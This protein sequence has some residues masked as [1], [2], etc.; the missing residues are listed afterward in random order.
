[1]TVPL[2]PEL[3]AALLAELEGRAPRVDAG[4]VGAAFDFAAAK[5]ERQKRESGRTSISQKLPGL[6]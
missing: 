1:M 2:H 6:F 3:R 5:H 4:R